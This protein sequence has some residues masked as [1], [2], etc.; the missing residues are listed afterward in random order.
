VSRN[1]KIAIGEFYHIYNRGVDRRDIFLDD[2]DYKRFY[3]LLFLCNGNKSFEI[4]DLNL[5]QIFDFDRDETLVDIGA[6]CLMDNHFHFLLREKKDN[7]ISEFMHKVS[8]AYTMYFNRK[9]KR[10]GSLFGGRFKAEHIGNDRYLNYLFAYIHLNP[11]KLIQSDWKESGIKDLEKAKE[12][13]NDY[14]FSSYLDYVNNSNTRH[15]GLILNKE[16]FPEYFASPKDFKDFINNW[17][18][19]KRDE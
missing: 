8:T 13:I 15:F 6:V 14:V 7:G 11:I 5:T 4:S 2:N 17:L 19:F 12:Y 3:Y 1:F 9:Y 18:L 16:A 10:T